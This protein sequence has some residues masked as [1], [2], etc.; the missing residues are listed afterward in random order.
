MEA[1]ADFFRVLRCPPKRTKMKCP[2]ISG[3]ALTIFQ[4]KF[5]NFQSTV[6]CGILWSLQI[7]IF[8]C[9]YYQNSTGHCTIHVL[10]CP[11]LYGARTYLN[12]PSVTPGETIGVKYGH[13]RGNVWNQFYRRCHIR[14]YH[15]VI[16][17]HALECNIWFWNE[18]Q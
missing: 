18:P 14:V 12:N 11:E 16:G 9:I 13:V 3:H 4:V 7:W 1:F 8:E 6:S 17:W 15:M 5:Q 2:E 10:I